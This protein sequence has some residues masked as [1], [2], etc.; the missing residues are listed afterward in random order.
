MINQLLSKMSINDRVNKKTIKLLDKQNNKAIYLPLLDFSNNKN[1]LF[2]AYLLYHDLININIK[3]YA[4]GSAYEVDARGSGFQIITSLLRSGVSEACG[5]TNQK[6]I[7]I[8][9]L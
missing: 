4:M 1:N 7:Y 8:P 2:E 3:S 6:D 5:M 9:N